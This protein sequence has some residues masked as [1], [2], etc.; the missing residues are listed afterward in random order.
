MPQVRSARLLA[1]GEPVRFEQTDNRRLLRDL[2]REPPDP[3][4]SVIALEAE[5][6][7]PVDGKPLQRLGAGCVIL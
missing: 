2:P 5:G 7:L 4:A 6:L 1:T 3:F